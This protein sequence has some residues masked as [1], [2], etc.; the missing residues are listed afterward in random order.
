[1]P[2]NIMEVIRA[3]L[4]MGSEAQKRVAVAV[5]QENYSYGQLLASACQ[6]SNT[7]LECNS[8]NASGDESVVHSKFQTGCNQS[9]NGAALQLIRKVKGMTCLKG[10]RIGIMAKPSAEF[11]A[12]MWATWIS[13]AVVVPLALSHP[14]TEILYVVN[15]AK[16]S[17]IAGTEEYQGL[18]EGISG[19]C[20]AR[21]C[22]IPVFANLPEYSE[23]F[24]SGKVKVGASSILFEDVLAEVE[25]DTT[26]TGDEAALIVYTSG[27]TGKP[28]GVVHTHDSIATQV[29]ILTEAWEYTP[30]DRVKHEA[31]L[32]LFGV[33]EQYRS[34]HL[35]DCF[36]PIEGNVPTMYARLLQAYEL[37]EIEAQK[38]AA[39]AAHKLRLMMCGSSA[40][41]HPV[42]KQW[43]KISGHRL[44]ER[45]GMTE[46]GMALSNPLHGQRK[47]GTLGKSL[48]GVEVKI[49][50]ANSNNQYE[51]G[52]GELCVK[53]PSM[54]KEYWRRPQ[55]TKES[56]GDDGYFRTGDTAMLDED[57]YFVMLG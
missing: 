39:S 40:L 8:A 41:P 46:F 19:K 18:L 37:M 36:F 33:A 5:A 23:A 50:S 24:M 51:P 4:K 10:A 13:G 43:E 6:L 12:G 26:V 54:F 2:D 25:K 35:A 1:Q 44:L 14:E 3:A 20:S 48:P 38:Y 42:M 22:L 53:S 49:I 9:T 30:A 16:I 15:D 27:T 29:Q 17:V 45:Y 11:V 7:L 32:N 21:F 57:G 31:V 52:I 47:M 56:F 34:L 55:A 28:K